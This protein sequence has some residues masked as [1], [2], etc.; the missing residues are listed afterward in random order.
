MFFIRLRF[1]SLLLIIAMTA[2]A[3]KEPPWPPKAMAEEWS[4]EYDK[5][6]KLTMVCSWRYGAADGRVMLILDKNKTK[7]LNGTKLYQNGHNREMTVEEINYYWKYGGAKYAVW[8]YLHTEGKVEIFN[9]GSDTEIPDTLHDRT[10]M[11]ITKDKRH[12]TGILKKTKSTD[13]M[14]SLEIKDSLDSLEPLLFHV[15][16]IKELRFF[17]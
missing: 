11:I 7:P 1:A 2:K 12:F 13:N 16:A 17:K 14:I 4:F 15:S 9:M 10:V 5:D 3:Q 8:Q 6:N